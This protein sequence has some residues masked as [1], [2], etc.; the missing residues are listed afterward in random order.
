[1]LSAY[2]YTDQLS[3]E[4]LTTRFITVEDIP[5]WAEFYHHPEATRFLHVSTWFSNDL[6]PDPLRLSEFII[7]K[8]LARYAEQRYGLQVILEKERATFLGLCGLVTQEV[9]GEQELEVGYHLLPA[10]WGRGYATEAAQM[11][12]D[13][14]KTNQL[15][16]SVISL[17]NPEN[18]PSRRV[19]ERN[20][21]TIDKF[22]RWPADQDVVVYR[23]MLL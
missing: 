6:N 17:I 12:L 1:M 2:H 8:Q 14:A 3:S 7:R 5:V 4:R 13:F 16:D 11:F 18:I 10:Y 22:T 9:D 20:G 21:L 19:A 23:K 15:A